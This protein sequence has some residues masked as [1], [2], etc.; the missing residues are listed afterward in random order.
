[1]PAAVKDEPITSAQPSLSV[2]LQQQQQQQQVLVKAEPGLALTEQLGLP[3]PAAASPLAGDG[4]ACN[5]AIV[6]DP[7]QGQALLQHAVSMVAAT[8]ATEVLPTQ[9]GAACNQQQGQALGSADTS[10]AAADTQATPPLQAA[11]SA[12]PTPPPPP[13]AAAAV[14]GFNP[15]PPA[16]PAAAAAAAVPGFNTGGSLPAGYRLPDFTSVLQAEQQLWVLLSEHLQASDCLLDQLEAAMALLD[17]TQSP[18]DVS[19]A[20]GKP[21]NPD[22]PDRPQAGPDSSQ[23]AGSNSSAGDGQ[24]CAAAKG[25]AA[26]DADVVAGGAGRFGAF[27]LQYKKVQTWVARSNVAKVQQA[28]LKMLQAVMQDR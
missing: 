22:G 24:E 26:A 18:D 3:A 15:T 4:C 20:A 14:P 17:Q 2:L 23:A 11:A 16:P 8:A 5:D 7:A 28:V 6:G 21:D 27:R 25:H 13:P 1:M 19:Q 9:Q 12:L 10:R